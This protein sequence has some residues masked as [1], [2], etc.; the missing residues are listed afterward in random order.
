MYY[1]PTHKASYR[2]RNNKDII[3]RIIKLCW[4]QCFPILQKEKLMLSLSDSLLLPCHTLF[5]YLTNSKEP[6]F[7]WSVGFCFCD[8]CN[9]WF[10]FCIFS[11]LK[12]T[13]ILK[14]TNNVEQVSRTLWFLHFSVMSFS[15]MKPRVQIPS[16]TTRIRVWEGPLFW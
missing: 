10:E 6:R 15:L 16:S 8:M 9:G 12:F 7:L 13:Q 5:P 11:F 2:I 3:I 1:L 14:Q 4:G